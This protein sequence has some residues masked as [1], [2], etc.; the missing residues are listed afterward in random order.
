MISTRRLD[1]V[2]IDPVAKTAMIQACVVWGD[3]V[4]TAAKDGLFP[5]TGSSGTVSAVGLLLGGGL[6]PLAR[7]HGICSDYLESAT[8]VTGSG[9]VLGVS[10]DSETDLFWALRGGKKVPG[11]VTDVTVRLTD[12][13]TLYGGALHFEEKDIETVMRAW[14]DWTGQADPRV[15]TSVLLAQFPDVDP[16]PPMFRGRRILSLRFAFP[17]PASEGER[18]AAPLRAAAPIYVDGLGEIPSTQID[19]VHSDPT[20]PVPFWTIGG[21]LTHVDQDFVST[22]LEATGPAAES[23][24]QMVEVRHVG[25]ATTRDVPDGS[26]VAGRSARNVVTVIAMDPSTFASAAPEAGTALRAALRPWTSSE[27]S[28]NLAGLS[29]NYEGMWSPAMATRL[30]EIRRRYDPEGRFTYAGS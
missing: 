8:V 7:S 14:V 2:T 20:M 12:L 6:S 15:T 19:R 23:P 18:L 30:D 28:P 27:N 1:A 10:R 17:G 21:L 11:I 26:A 9:D 24:F 16:I 3:V 13:Q 22:L 25:E 4:A 29:D 5:I